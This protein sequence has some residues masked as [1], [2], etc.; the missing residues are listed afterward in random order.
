MT[1]WPTNL[2]A[3]N[4][5]LPF[6]QPYIFGFNPNM[7]YVGGEDKWAG[8]LRLSMG[9][10]SYVV[11]AQRS[12]LQKICK[13]KD[14][15]DIIK[16]FSELTGDMIESAALKLYCARQT[17]PP[18]WVIAECVDS[19]EAVIGLNGLWTQVSPAGLHGASRREEKC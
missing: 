13:E 15:R 10:V 8:Q 16:C 19:E 4:H 3:G 9:G 11:L 7:Q 18:G 1:S 14:A 5:L 2:P 17:C 12:E 6:V